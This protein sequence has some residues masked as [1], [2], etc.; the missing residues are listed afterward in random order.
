MPNRKPITLL[1]VL[2][3]P[4]HIQR[5]RVKCRCEVAWTEL[6]P[7]EV[8]D[9]SLIVQFECP[10]CHTLYHLQNKQLTRV[11]EDALNE[12]KRAVDFVKQNGSG[13]HYDA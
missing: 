9:S 3:D 1:T 13:E 5:I 11:R 8:H 12:L 2:C 4:K 6:V 10:Q 7:A